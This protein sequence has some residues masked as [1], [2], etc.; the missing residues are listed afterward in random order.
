[1]WA[2]ISLAPPRASAVMVAM[3]DSS[4]MTLPWT[5]VAG[6]SPPRQG[7]MVG[8][9]EA[10]GGAVLTEDGSDVLDGLVGAAGAVAGYRDG[11]GA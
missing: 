10:T 7:A 9:E 2:G 3:A 6:L 5:A 11:N 8:Q 4:R 1:M